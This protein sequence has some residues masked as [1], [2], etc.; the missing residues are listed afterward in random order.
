MAC[1][2]HE[3]ALPDAASTAPMF[4]RG[5][6]PIELNRP[7][8]YTRVPESSSAYVD[9]CVAEIELL[10]RADGTATADNALRAATIV[11]DTPLERQHRDRLRVKVMES[12]LHA[13]DSDQH[14][15]IDGRTVF[16][17]PITEPELRLDVS[18]LGSVYLGGFTFAELQCACRVEELVPGAVARANEL[19][20]VDAAPWCP[21]IF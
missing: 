14:Q 15:A 18:A 3:T 11:D 20:R 10:L 9:A 7:P 19:F 4:E 1:G 21:E 17:R 8:A 2:L 13:A 12:L 6:P 5:C 16:D